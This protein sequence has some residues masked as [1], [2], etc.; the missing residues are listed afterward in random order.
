MTCAVLDACVLIGS[1]RRHALLM[2][3]HAEAY[4]PVW[5]NTILQEVRHNLPKALGN[6]GLDTASQ[7]QHAEHICELL[8]H[9]FPGALTSAPDRHDNQPR[10]PDPDDAHVLAL[11][12]ACGA[13]TIVTENIRDF[14]KPVLSQLGLRAIRTDDF[15]VELADQKPDQAIKAFQF[16]T[17]I[18]MGEGF[19][20]EDIYATFHRVGL[21]KLT[22]AL[23]KIT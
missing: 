21:K 2:F 17:D 18:L 9:A 14:P 16:L 20:A 5:S 12:I 11:A 19:T 15:L 6:S 13:D 22:R 4:E 1:V 8:Q 3:A 7:Q 10:L 23:Q